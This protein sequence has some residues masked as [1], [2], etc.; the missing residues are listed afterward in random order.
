MNPVFESENISFVKVC[1][2]FLGD[3]L[4]ML[5]DPDKAIW[6]L[7]FQMRSMKKASRAI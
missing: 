6:S 1:E 4:E 7:R 3:Y 5:N 2:N